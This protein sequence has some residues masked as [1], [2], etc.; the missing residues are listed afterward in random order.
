M[1]LA[2]LRYEVVRWVSDE[3]QPGRVEVRVAD[4]DGRQWTFFDK[5]PIFEY[6]G[7]LASDAAYPQKACLACEV[8]GTVT[9]P[10]GREVLSA[11]TS[12]ALVRR[13]RRR[14]D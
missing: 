11:S 3:P 12:T 1:A 2:M 9:W 14:P 10:D 7:R 8:I 6:E 4:V 13:V 5:P